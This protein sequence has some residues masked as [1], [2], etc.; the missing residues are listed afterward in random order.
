VLATAK[1]RG[2]AGPSAA[3]WAAARAAGGSPLRVDDRGDLQH[4][5]ADLIDA[6]AP[7]EHERAERYRLTP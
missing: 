6:Y 5:V 2:F 1:A 7:S 3:E 4:E